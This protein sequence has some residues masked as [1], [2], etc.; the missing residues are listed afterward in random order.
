[1]VLMQTSCPLFCDD[2]HVTC[3]RT[4]LI[5]HLKWQRDQHGRRWGKSTRMIAANSQNQQPEIDMSSL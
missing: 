5:Q 2:E 1:M 4:W 3:K